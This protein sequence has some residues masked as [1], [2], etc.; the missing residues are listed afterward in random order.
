[1]TWVNVHEREIANRKLTRIQGRAGTKEDL[2]FTDECYEKEG[3][4][5]PLLLNEI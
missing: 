1:M 4:E 2:L 5:S 3:E